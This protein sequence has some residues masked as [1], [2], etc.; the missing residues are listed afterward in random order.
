M[1]RDGNGD[2][3]SEFVTEDDEDTEVVAEDDDE[4]DALSDGDAEF[5]A[6]ADEEYDGSGDVLTSALFVRDDTAVDDTDS[7]GE[8]VPES[9][10]GFE[11]LLDGLAPRVNVAV[12]V[13]L[14]DLEAVIVVDGVQVAVVVIEAVGVGEDVDA[15]VADGEVLTAL[16][17][18][19]V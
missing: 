11:L 5:V 7:L 10:L 9:D 14:M 4:T 12:G 16:E 13:L 8:S 6:D 15:A 18:L 3:E 1:K 17:S 2:T 19:L